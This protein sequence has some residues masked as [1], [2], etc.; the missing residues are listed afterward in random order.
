MEALHQ[1]GGVPPRWKFTLPPGNAMAGRQVFIDLSCYSCH[2]I[3]GEQFPVKPGDKTDAGPELTGMGSHHPAEYFAESILNLNAVLIEGRG[4]IGPDGR[5]SMP[6]YPDMTL[7]QLTDLVAYL[8]SLTSGETPHAHAEGPILEQVV[9][10]YR[11]RLVYQGAKAGGHGGH[12]GKAATT[13]V[14]DHLMVF[15]ADV[16]TGEPIPYLPIR[17]TIHA[18]KKPAKAVR[19]LPMVGGKGFHYGADLAL[20]EK[21]TKITLSIG[22]TTT[23]VMPS[24]AG[25]FGKPL[26][27]TFDW[28]SHK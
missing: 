10:D 12:A 20:P 9:G 26:T 5:S 18:E 25:R 16:E 7:A 24:A 21:T 14:H 17:A 1:T 3:K 15:I 6:T 28:S 2:V 8:K 22:A 23:R 19:L 27:I 4:Y 13:H 11:I